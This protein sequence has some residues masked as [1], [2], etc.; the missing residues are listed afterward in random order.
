[1]REMSE[2]S[3]T[4]GRLNS[5]YQPTDERLMAVVEILIACITVAFIAYGE[6]VS[7]DLER[8]GA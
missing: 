1:M 6:R 5:A 8:L 2:P 3:R 4:L 7:L